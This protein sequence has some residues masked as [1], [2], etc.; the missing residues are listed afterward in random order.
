MVDGQLISTVDIILM[1]IQ[2]VLPTGL[3]LSKQELARQ[4]KWYYPLLFGVISVT[5]YRHYC[6]YGYFI[7][8]L[9]NTSLPHTCLQ[10]TPY[11][12]A[13]HAQLCQSS[14][15]TKHSKTGG[16]CGVVF[17]IPFSTTALSAM[18]RTLWTH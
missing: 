1:S 17:F 6:D 7:S 12:V 15:Q 2:N 18:K 11:C 8:C 13:I 4:R 14:G 9:D 10:T 16:H 3:S 5:G